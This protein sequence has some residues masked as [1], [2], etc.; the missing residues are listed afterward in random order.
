MSKYYVKPGDVL[1]IN[2]AMLRDWYEVTEVR[3]DQI[4]VRIGGSVEWIWRYQIAAY[5]RRETQKEA[6]QDREDWE[7]LQ[8]EISYELS[9]DREG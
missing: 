1:L 9:F 2:D 4:F 7:R 8:D 3:G 6:Q 5:A